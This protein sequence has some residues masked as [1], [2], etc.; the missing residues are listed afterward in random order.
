MQPAEIQV[1]FM[2]V[3]VQSKVINLLQLYLLFG[4]SV[5]AGVVVGAIGGVASGGNNSHSTDVSK[6]WNSSIAT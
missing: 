3:S 1:I 2:D 4:G 6:N 5:G